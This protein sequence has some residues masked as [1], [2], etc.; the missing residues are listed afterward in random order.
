MKIKRFFPWALFL[1][2][3]A[4]LSLLA[5]CERAPAAGKMPEPDVYTCYGG[6]RYEAMGEGWPG[7]DEWCGILKAYLT[8]HTEVEARALA[9]QKHVP[10]WIV[11][12]LEKCS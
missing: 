8:S 1:V 6:G 7:C 4:I 5:M 11:R 2:M 10:A 3:A 9:V 12:K